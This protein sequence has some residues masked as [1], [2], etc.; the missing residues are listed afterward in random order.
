M[1]LPF[2][3]LQATEA[4]ASASDVPILL[5]AQTVGALVSNPLWGWWGDARGKRSLLEILA[6][7]GAVAPLLTLSWITTGGSGAATPLSW[8]AVTFVVLGAVGNAV[9]SPISAI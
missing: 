8:F 9:P 3:I 4:G 2:Y 1:A 7:G 6:A 5:A